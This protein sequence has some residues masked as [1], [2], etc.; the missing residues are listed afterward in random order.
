[1][2]ADV[3]GYSR[4]MATDEVGTYGRIVGLYHGVLRPAA[5]RLGGDIGE[6]RGDG[7]LAGAAGMYRAVQWADAAHAG[8]AATGSSAAL[9]LALRIAIH[10]GEVLITEDGVFGDAVNLT[11]RLQEH[12]APGGTA[13]SEVVAQALRDTLDEVLVDLGL[14]RFKND[15]RPFR[16]YALGTAHAAPQPRR[17]G[18]LPS[19]AVLPLSNVGGNPADAYLAAGIMDDVILSL[20]GLR[21]L[22]VISRGSTTAA[23]GGPPADPVSAGR[24]LGVRYVLSGNLLRNGP[25]I[26][27]ATQ[28]THVETGQSLWAD[29]QGGREEG[30]FDLQDRIVQRIVAGMAPNIR[31]TELRATLR[32][33][34]ES[35]TAYDRTL[36]GVH[37]IYSLDRETSR[38]AKA[39]LDEAIAED[40]GFP[41]PMAYAAWWHVLWIGQRWVEDVTAATEAA[42]NL[43]TRAIALDPGHALALSA[44]GQILSFLSRRSRNQ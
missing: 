28:L 9:P 13:V 26:R 38:Q 6:L 17:L 25:A 32:K 36:R 18:E 31:A 43:S 2:F 29:R 5:E 11:A 30:V 10:T 19:I 21:E 16:A 20:S 3:V 35:L 41:L 7:A 14:L 34:P 8:A 37:L 27:V 44:H 4:L 23:T 15:V 42:I 1:V 12:A 22:A 39:Y 40:P 33:R 24:A